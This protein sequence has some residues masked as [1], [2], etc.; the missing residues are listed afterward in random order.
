MILTSHRLL[1]YL[2]HHLSAWQQFTL[3]EPQRDATPVI[4]ALDAV[5]Q[6]YLRSSEKHPLFDEP[7]VIW[8]SDPDHAL[9]I[10]C[11]LQ[12]N[13]TH[14]TEDAKAFRLVRTNLPAQCAEQLDSL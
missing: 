5:V 4:S 3:I 7:V 1:W 9:L 8:W 6:T 2:I 13:G 11:R 10:P 12:N 14:L